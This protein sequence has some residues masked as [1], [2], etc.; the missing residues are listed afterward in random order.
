MKPAKFGKMK[1]LD[2]NTQFQEMPPGHEKQVRD[3]AGAIRRGD[4]MRPI[5]VSEGGYLQDGRHRL[6]AYKRL[7]IE[8]IEVEYG[9]HPAAKV[10]RKRK[11]D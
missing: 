4:K 5:L 7:G 6:A 11:G 9:Y 2:I 3:I 10:I 1:V 8:E